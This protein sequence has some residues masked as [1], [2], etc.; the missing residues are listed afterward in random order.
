MATENDRIASMM[1]ADAAP[2]AGAPQPDVPPSGPMSSPMST[3][4]PKFGSKE[5]AMVNLSMAL[6][7]IEQSLPALGSE[8]AEGKQAVA[9]LRTLSGLL[10]P[11]KAKTAELQPAEIQQLLGALPQ[12]GGASPE[13]KAMAAAPPIPGG[14]PPAPMPGAPGP[15]PQPMM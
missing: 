10:G 8:S 14:A 13:A 7:L 4:E 3:P 2:G 5:A 6:D 9:A 1:R 15:V 12:A 11:K